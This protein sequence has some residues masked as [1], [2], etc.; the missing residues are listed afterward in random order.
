MS[1]RKK[2]IS[3]SIKPDAV[4]RSTVVSML[5]SRVLMD[6]KRSLA[7]RIVYSTLQIIETRTQ[8]DPL[9]VLEKA[10]RH[11]TPIV[12]VKSRRIGGSIYQIPQ[13]IKRSRG[14]TLAVKW[15]LQGAQSRNAF[16]FSEKLAQEI[17]DASQSLGSAIKKKEEVH[18]MAE[19]N[20]AFAHFKS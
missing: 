15:L 7:Q 3:K 4:Y 17:I 18:R 13:E 20:K 10:L 5:I 11:V 6:G 14:T 1:R 2:N 12:E 19:A 9:Q 16:S 8:E